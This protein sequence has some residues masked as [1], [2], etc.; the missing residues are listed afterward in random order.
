MACCQVKEKMIKVAIG[1]ERKLSKKLKYNKIMS[2]QEWGDLP[3]YRYDRI[4]YFEQCARPGFKSGA[5]L[6]RVNF[7]RKNVTK[8]LQSAVCSKHIPV[9]ERISYRNAGL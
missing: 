3:V 1:I 9:A 5:T 8:K 2:I 6:K 4:R 7:K